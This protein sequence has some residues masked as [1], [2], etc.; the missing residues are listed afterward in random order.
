[1]SLSIFLVDAVGQIDDSPSIVQFITDKQA[2][3]ADAALNSVASQD[4][5]IQA[6]Q[7]T[8]SRNEAALDEW[9]GRTGT[10]QVNFISQVSCEPCY[11]AG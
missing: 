6:L 1:M 5:S 4:R 2:K 8:T 9:T 10:Y 11:T 3:P 7:P